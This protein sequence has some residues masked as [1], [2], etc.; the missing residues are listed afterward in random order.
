M[1]PTGQFCL[2]AFLLAVTELKTLTAVSMP[3]HGSTCES[4]CVSL[5]V[6]TPTLSIPEARGQSP[7][8]SESKSEG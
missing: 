4:T 1:A 8:R 3:S 6:W 2:Y 5:V 7:E